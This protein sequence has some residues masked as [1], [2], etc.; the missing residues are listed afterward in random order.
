MNETHVTLVGNVVA[1]PVRR[2]TK[3]GDPYVT[4]RVASTVRRYDAAT[5]GYVDVD[6]S[7]V[8]VRAFRRLA[9]HVGDSVRRGH[10]VVVNGRLR[11]REWTNGERAG[12]AVEIDAR[13]VG[14]DLTWGTA[15]FRRE[16]RLG[17]AR[18]A[19]AEGE[20]DAEG[21]SASAWDGAPAGA[22]GSDAWATTSAHDPSSG[23]DG[24]GA[25]AGAELGDPEND[26]YA[27]AS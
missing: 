26:A 10:P 5:G 23:D 12:T 6:T 25:D 13:T 11:V 21:A 22:G 16:G 1:D 2:L 14:H 4:F 7:F 27:V 9:R 8:D 15:V 24:V 17:E 20:Y 18:T 3:N 19:I